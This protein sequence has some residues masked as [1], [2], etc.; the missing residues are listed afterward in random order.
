MSNAVNHEN[1]REN[2]EN[3]IKNLNN[4]WNFK[5]NR[6]IAIFFITLILTAKLILFS[7]KFEN[8]KNP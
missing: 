5:N 8:L 1:N 6:I 3:K 4:N 7:Q 2:R